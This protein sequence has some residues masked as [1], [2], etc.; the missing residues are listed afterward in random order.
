VIAQLEP[1]GMIDP[2]IT[3]IGWAQARQDFAADPQSG[4]ILAVGL[5]RTAPGTHPTLTGLP[6]C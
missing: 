5:D 3:R 1:D 4:A 2:R 6:G